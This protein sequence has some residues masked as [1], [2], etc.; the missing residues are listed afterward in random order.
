MSHRLLRGL[1]ESL[2]GIASATRLAAWARDDMLPVASP[3]AELLGSA[4]LRRGGS[5]VVHG[6]PVPGAT[7]LLL[8]LLAAPTSSG[9]WCAVVGAPELGVVAAKELGVALDHLLLVPDPGPHLLPVVGAL[10]DGCDVVCLRLPA[11]FAPAEGRRLV[12]RARERRSVL[13]VASGS[14][15][16][17]TGAGGIAQLPSPGERRRVRPG[18][19]LEVPD[20]H[21][22]V[23]ASRVSGAGQGNGRVDAHLLQVV[24]RRRRAAPEELARWLWLPD[25]EGRLTTADIAEVSHDAAVL[26]S[27]GTT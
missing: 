26:R 10:L 11:A 25:A 17:L 16:S 24:A 23:Q 3:L 15:A 12:A 6:G 1:P 9:A 5:I 27:T 7:S 22:S 4:G 21:L 14:T 20:V 2:A 13:V 18:A 19:W 8:A